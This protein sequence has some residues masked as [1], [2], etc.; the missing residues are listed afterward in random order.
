MRVFV[1][2]ISDVGDEQE[3][4]MTR[5]GI[6]TRASEGATVLRAAT[7]EAGDV[8]LPL[9]LRGRPAGAMDWLRCT[10]SGHTEPHLSDEPS[11]EMLTLPAP[12]LAGAI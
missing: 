3:L 12:E 5:R 7:H 4:T 10:G 9:P 8:M 6:L 11:G 1:G 2:P